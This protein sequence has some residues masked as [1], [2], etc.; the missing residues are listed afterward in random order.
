MLKVDLAGYLDQANALVGGEV[1]DF[2]IAIVGH[3]IVACAGIDRFAGRDRI[4]AG[5]RV[6]SDVLATRGEEGDAQGPGAEVGTI[7][8]MV[9]ECVRAGPMVCHACATNSRACARLGSGEAPSA[10]GGDALSF[11]PGKVLEGRLLRFLP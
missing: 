7:R 8:A 2:E 3:R 11:S 9:A 6:D 10:G 5:A 4:G 1:L